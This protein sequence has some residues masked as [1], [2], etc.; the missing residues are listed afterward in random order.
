MFVY[1]LHTTWSNEDDDGSEVQVFSEDHLEDARAAMRRNA[2]E[3]KACYH[4][5]NCGDPWE[6][7]Y[8]WESEDDIHLGF[9][10]Q[11][12]GIATIYSWEIQHLE[13]K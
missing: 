6:D 8:T 4:D 12:F 11:P 5:D 10:D 13:V 9:C 3:I 2:A 1:V 7:D